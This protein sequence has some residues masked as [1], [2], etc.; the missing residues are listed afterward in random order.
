LGQAD[1]IVS[2]PGHPKGKHTIISQIY[3]EWRVVCCDS[4]PFDYPLGF[5]FLSLSLKALN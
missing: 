3:F 1:A 5:Y 4:K 2:H